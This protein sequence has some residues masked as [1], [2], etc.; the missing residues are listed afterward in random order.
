MVW[1]QLNWLMRKK[2]SNPVDHYWLPPRTTGWV[3]CWFLLWSNCGI[4]IFQLDRPVI[5]KLTARSNFH[6][7]VGNM[8]II[9]N[10]C[11]VKYH[12]TSIP[13]PPLQFQSPDGLRSLSQ[14]V[15]AHPVS[16][17]PRR[18]PRCATCRSPASHPSS[19]CWPPWSC[20]E[21]SCWAAPPTSVEGSERWLPSWL[22][23]WLS[24]NWL[25]V[26]DW[27]ASSGEYVYSPLLV[28]IIVP[29]ASLIILITTPQ[30][31]HWSHICSSEDL[32]LPSFDIQTL[33]VCLPPL[34]LRTPGNVYHRCPLGRNWAAG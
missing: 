26:L 9:R 1:G 15:E 34:A 24:P 13:S 32:L 7:V 16:S 6:L 4:V 12:V 17:S 10:I 30:S 22:A 14:S 31:P 28:R 2:P 5:I 18:A 20:P 11:A 3:K 19:G 23:G 33:P 29:S 21:P 8:Q 27:L 25:S